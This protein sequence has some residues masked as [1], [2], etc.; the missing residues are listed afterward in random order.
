MARDKDESG[1]HAVDVLEQTD[2]RR[3][4]P[5]LRL[6]D[7]KACNHMPWLGGTFTTSTGCEG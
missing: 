1:N 4:P 3:T 6:H 2:N 5:R 7:Q